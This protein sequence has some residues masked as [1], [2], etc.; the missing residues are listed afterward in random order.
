MGKLT[1]PDKAT[2]KRIGKSCIVTGMALLVISWSLILFVSLLYRYNPDLDIPDFV[3]IIIYFHAYNAW[4]PV[5]IGISFWIDAACT[6]RLIRPLGFASLLT[7]ERKNPQS[8]TSYPV[9]RRTIILVG[10]CALCFGWIVFG[11]TLTHKNCYIQYT[12]LGLLVFILSENIMLSLLILV[13]CLK[14]WGMVVVLACIYVLALIG[15]AQDPEAILGA[16]FP[17]R[18]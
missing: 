13:A 12:G 11:Y 3:L 5:L 2:I 1:K 18:Y 15:F 16:I 17:P 7:L 9:L 6:S 14:K 8:E 4:L 10:T